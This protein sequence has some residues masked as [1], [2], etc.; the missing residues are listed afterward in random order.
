MTGDLR[1]RLRDDERQ[2][3]VH[4]VLSAGGPATPAALRARMAAPSR[5]APAPARRRVALAG[6][7]GAVALAAVLVLTLVVELGTHPTI[8]EAARPSGLTAT[9]PAP[10]RDPARPA[11]LRAAFAGVTFPEWDR[12]FQWRA[13]GRRRD[14][15]DGRTAETIFYEH[16]H[17]RI[18]YTVLSGK[19]LKPPDDADR[20]VVN[21]LE[22]RAYSD[23][24]RDVVVFERA[25][26]TCV[27]AGEV[28]RRSTLLK[29]A[30]WRGDGAIAF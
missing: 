8:A 28:H 29:L 11:L 18:G 26:R 27:L 23:G 3:R 16:A 13:T 25:G 7:V 22:L 20:Y 12:N 1:S 30:S 5:P 2:R 15:L 6:A 4:G 17:H 10:T 14:A 24:P 9:A 19:P 21:G